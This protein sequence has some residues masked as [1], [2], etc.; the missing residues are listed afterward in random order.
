MAFIAACFCFLLVFFFILP[1]SATI[2]HK[3]THYDFFNVACND[4]S[5]VTNCTRSSSPS[6]RVACVKF[7]AHTFFFL[8]IQSSLGTIDPV[9]ILPALAVCYA[10]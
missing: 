6:D 1:Y 9:Q 5:P 3:F 2:L 10:K 4:E 8:A 7:Q